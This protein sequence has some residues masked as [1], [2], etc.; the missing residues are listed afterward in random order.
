MHQKRDEIFMHR[1]LQLAQ[2]ALGNTYPNPMVGAVVVHNDT[3]IGEGYH[4]KAGEPHA[5][6]LAIRAVKNKE[7][8][9]LS[10]LFVNLEPCSHIGRT[11][12][13][14]SLIL[15]SKIPTVVIGCIDSYKEV[16][17]AGIDLLKA[18]A[19][20]VKVGVLEKES[21]ELNRRF[22]TFHEKKRPYIILKWAQTL[23]GYI[24]FIRQ[25]DTPIQPNWITD[26]YARILV[27]KWR[28]EE[29][30][31]MAATNTVEKDNPQLNVRDW[32]GH[33][34]IRIILDRTLRLKKELSVFDDRQK[35]IVF[36]EKSN[37]RSK[38]TE[39]VNISFGE[40]FYDDFCRVLY[41]KNI[42]SVFIEG[43]ATFLQNLIDRGYWDEAR[44]F[45]GTM[46]FLNGVKAPIIRQQPVYDG[47]FSGS[48][49]HVYRNILSGDVGLE[50]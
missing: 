41:E 5:E 44:V 34:P 30:A 46:H 36:T 15:E 11:P 16:S 28:S 26:D 43:G 20:N 19:V 8:L 32:K 3:I 21:R 7:L 33:Q 12:A 50:S 49:L 31:V 24:D 1:C 22:F 18:A 29:Q 45:T 27:H 10:T 39:Y 23:D 4:Q 2:N 47:R 6:V 13:C 37:A 40:T 42:Q 48:R 14:A 25:A 9:K 38:Q 17:G 35:T